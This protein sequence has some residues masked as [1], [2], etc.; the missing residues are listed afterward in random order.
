M[1]KER[2][3]RLKKDFCSPRFK[4][5]ASVQG[6]AS[7]FANVLG[8]Q[9]EH[10]LI[11]DYDSGRG[12]SEWLEEIITPPR[13]NWCDVLHDRSGVASFQ[14]LIKCAREFNYKFVMFN[15]SVFYTETEAY[16][17]KDKRDIE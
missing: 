16:T 3:F 9:S 6:T 2:R 13:I 4:L 11:L 1:Y 10:T 8:Y 14:S 7:Y 12:L 5:S 17:L 15:N